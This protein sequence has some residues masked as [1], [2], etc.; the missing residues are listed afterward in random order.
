[1]EEFLQS[2]DLKNV[3][4]RVI[5]IALILFFAKVL[6]RISKR[7]TARV[8][9]RRAQRLPEAKQKKAETS[10]SIIQ[11]IA[12]YVIWFLAACGIIGE[13][14]LTSTMYSLLATAGIGGLALGI[15]A[16][17]FIKDVMAGM[18]LLFED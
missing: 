2:I 12:Q 6:V 4:W 17:S 11:S 13:L 9:S 18:F 5:S 14:G 10:S 16:Q 1:M 3:L 7:V 15:G 8:Y